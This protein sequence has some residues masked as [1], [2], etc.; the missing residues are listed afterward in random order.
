MHEQRSF[1]SK[2]DFPF[3]GILFIILVDYK[4]VGLRVKN[5]RFFVQCSIGQQEY[6]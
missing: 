6:E 3:F 2:K 1:P 4:T 5:R